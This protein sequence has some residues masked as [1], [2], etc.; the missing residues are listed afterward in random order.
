MVAWTRL[1]VRIYVL[2]FVD[3]L[4]Y[5]LINYQMS[6][7]QGGASVPV[8]LDAGAP[9]CTIC[10]R[11]SCCPVVANF[12][13]NLQLQLQFISEDEDNLTLYLLT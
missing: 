12:R 3:L 1:S 5:D 9:E 4:L 8:W 6:K 13:R 11:S 10:L 7:S 2:F